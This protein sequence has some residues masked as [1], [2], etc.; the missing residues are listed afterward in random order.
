MTTND[1][2]KFKSF[3]DHLEYFQNLNSIRINSIFS[4]ADIKISLYKEKN[5]VLFYWLARTKRDFK[6]RKSQKGS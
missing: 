1:N 2:Y 6:I 4:D 5:R 3:K